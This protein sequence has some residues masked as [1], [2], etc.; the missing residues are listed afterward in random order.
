MAK[1]IDFNIKGA[2]RES[3]IVIDHFKNEISTRDQS[4]KT[5]SETIKKYADKFGAL[6]K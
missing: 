1:K 5:M 6:T 3:I 2:N 4:I